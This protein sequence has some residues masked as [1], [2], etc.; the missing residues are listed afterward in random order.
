MD[1]QYLCM[2]CT[3]CNIIFVLLRVL[4]ARLAIECQRTVLTTG[5]VCVFQ[6]PTDRVADRIDTEREEPRRYVCMVGLEWMLMP[7]WTLAQGRGP[8]TIMGCTP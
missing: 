3:A 5:K 4:P 6:R 7:P 8:G 2:L 1:G